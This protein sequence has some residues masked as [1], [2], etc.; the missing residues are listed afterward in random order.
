MPFVDTY[1]HNYRKNL[2]SEG[3]D[4]FFCLEKARKIIYLLK[5][6]FLLLGVIDLSSLFTYFVGVF[7]EA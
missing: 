1:L 4:Y 3:K 5:G 2:S 6:V 7:C